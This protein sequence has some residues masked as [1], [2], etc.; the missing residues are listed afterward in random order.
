MTRTTKAADRPPSMK[1]V[2]RLAGVSLGTVSH[3]LNK[4]ERVSPESLQKVHTAI[5]QL[6]FV[7]NSAARSLAAGVSSTVGLVLTDIDNS[8][9]VD[10]ARGA[11]DEARR[12]KHNLLLANSDVDLERQESYLD[13]FD[14]AR[15]A[16]ILFAPMNATLEGIDRVRRH[17][18]RIVLVNYAG[19]REDC[20]AV[21]S[22]EELGG[23][24]ATG[25]LIGLG[26]RRLLF[27]GGPEE[28]HAIRARLNGARRAVT[29]AG[30]VTL[31]VIG[32]HRLKSDEGRRIAALVAARARGERPDGIFAPSDRIAAG[33]IH[34]LMARGLRVPED[35][36]V[37]GYDDNQFAT[38]AAIPM[39]TVTQHGHEM[40]AAAMRLLLDEIRNPERHEHRVL[41]LEPRLVPRESTLGSTMSPKAEEGLARV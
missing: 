9:F 14:E 6:G 40:G 29:E 21:I 41:T 10:I 32:S 18:R 26:R 22:D 20:C 2:A 13:I 23:Y 28:F 3:A 12:S 5:E 1:E 36:A 4:P 31:E 25:H 35:V 17:G 33:I 24:I 39:S 30:N 16:G 8:L 37:I 15:V 34:E 27:A 38:E 11:E 7:R 19:G